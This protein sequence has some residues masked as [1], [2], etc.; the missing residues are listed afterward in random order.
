MV[1]AGGGCAAAF[2]GASELHTHPM[3]STIAFVPLVCG[4]GA[5]AALVVHQYLVK[6]PLMPVR[7]ITT[8]FPTEGIIIAMTAGAASVAAIELAQQA[9]QGPGSPTHTAMLFWPESGGAVATALLFGAIFRTR[10]VP[11]LAW[12][13][14]LLLA[15]GAAVLQ[16]SPP[17]RTCSSWSAQA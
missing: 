1:L 8:T 14:T 6:R 9:L 7:Q 4:A 3:M 13:G 11:L 12:A 15:G 10:F 2:F 17:A 16:A 5:V